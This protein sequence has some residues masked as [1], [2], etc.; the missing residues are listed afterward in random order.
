MIKPKY[1]RHLQFKP[2]YVRHLQM[3]PKNIG[4]VFQA[5]IEFITGRTMKRM[6]IVAESVDLERTQA[7]TMRRRVV[8]REERLIVNM[9]KPPTIERP[10]AVVERDRRRR[11][12]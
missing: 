6:E 5:M 10:L 2:K 8:M 7:S 3:D 11:R 12:A 4:K 1:V 9:K